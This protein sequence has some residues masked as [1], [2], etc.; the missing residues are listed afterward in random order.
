MKIEKARVD[1]IPPEALYGMA[2]A[3]EDG[4]V[5]YGAHDWESKDWSLMDRL[6]ASMRHVLRLISKE[7]F[8]ADSGV[9]HAAH[10]L[11][12]AAMIYTM[13][14]RGNCGKDDR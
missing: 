13:S 5:K 9:H 6:A 3:F 11:A 14:V 7:D 2:E 1:L 8:A 4:A 12:D 10:L